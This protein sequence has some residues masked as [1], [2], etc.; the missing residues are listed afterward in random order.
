MDTFSSSHRRTYG[1][2]PAILFVIAML[3]ACG[4]G[5]AVTSHQK[6]FCS[7]LPSSSASPH[8]ASETLTTVPLPGNPFGSVITT[9]GQ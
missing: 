9:D 7:T 3:T 6:S 4:S 5:N 2:L 1:R 8:K